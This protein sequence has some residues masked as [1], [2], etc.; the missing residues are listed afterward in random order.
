MSFKVLFSP[1]ASKEFKKLDPSIKEHLKKEI[2]IERVFHR[3][4][5][6]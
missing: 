1:K 6:Y 5:D 4:K 3:G 2:L